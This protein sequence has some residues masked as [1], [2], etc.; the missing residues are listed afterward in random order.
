MSVEMLCQFVE[1]GNK[2]EGQALAHKLIDEVIFNALCIGLDLLVARG[3]TGPSRRQLQ[4]VER[5]LARQCLA[6]VLLPL[7]LLA[8]GIFFAA[9]RGQ[10]RIRTQLI[11]VIEIF[12]T[13]GQPVN[14][15]AQQIQH[16]MLDQLFIPVIH[17]ALGKA[18]EITVGTI[19]PPQ[20]HAP[21]V[22]GNLASFKIHRDRFAVN[23]FWKKQWLI[24][25]VCRVNGGGGGFPF[26][27]HSKRLNNLIAV[28]HSLLVRNSG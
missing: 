27:L 13:Q 9:H 2:S 10:Q 12:V 23:Q 21:S 8:Q 6:P 22:T 26:C 20:Q 25:T 5:A 24:V 28:V 18:L 1:S 7:P 15:L 19:Q 14:A 16:R 11:M 4:P 17:E 3:P